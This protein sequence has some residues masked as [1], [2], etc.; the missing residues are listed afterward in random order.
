MYNKAEWTHVVCRVFHHI[1]IPTT[2]FF[3]SIMFYGND[4]WSKSHFFWDSLYVEYIGL[5]INNDV[6]LLMM[7]P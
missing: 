1:L 2:W 7:C 6:L 5:L 4:I 3:L